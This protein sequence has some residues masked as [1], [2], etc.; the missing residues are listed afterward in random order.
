MS[1]ADNLGN[2]RSWFPIPTAGRGIS[3]GRWL[4]LEGNRYAV[5][6]AL[7]TVTFASILSIG[8]IWTFEMQRLLVETQAVQSLLNTFLSGIILLVSIVVSI[9][10]IILSYDITH[11]SDQEDRIEGMM[12]FWQKLSR[13]SDTNESPT[14]PNTFLKVMADVIRREARELE[15]TTRGDEEA[16]A[17]EVREYLEQITETAEHLENSLTNVRGGKFGTL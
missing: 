5:T 3:L 7:L 14:D 15:E 17:K 9:N 12:N 11:V 6:G 8:T 4:L 2:L 1:L 16:F 10:S 13:I